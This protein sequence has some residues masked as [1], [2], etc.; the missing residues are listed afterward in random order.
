VEL[1]AFYEKI[2][3][4][5][6]TPR[7][8]AGLFFASFAEIPILYRIPGR[9]EKKNGTAD[10]SETFKLREDRSMQLE[11]NAQRALLTLLSVPSPILRAHYN[12]CERS[13][14]IFVRALPK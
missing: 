9:G 13:P 4:T 2:N 12:Q 1:R 3:Q 10:R 5:F 11:S 8:T 6:L 7:L 14:L